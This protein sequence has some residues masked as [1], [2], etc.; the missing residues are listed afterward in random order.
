MRLRRPILG[1]VIAGTGS[2]LVLFAL[3][4]ASTGQTLGPVNPSGKLCSFET[5][6]AFVRRSTPSLQ[7]SA[8]FIENPIAVPDRGQIKE[9]DVYLHILGR[10]ASSHLSSI[11][12]RQCSFGFSVD[13]S[14]GLEFELINIGTEGHSACSFN[15]CVSLLS[16]LIESAAIDEKEFSAAASSIT[17]AMREADVVHL[18]I[19]DLAWSAQRRKSCV[20]FMDRTPK[21]V[22][23]LIFHRATLQARTSKSF[24]DGLAISKTY[25]APG[26]DRKSRRNRLLPNPK[27][28]SVDSLAM[29]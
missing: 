17:A 15:Q 12:L 23:C 4:V 14:S 24:R 22:F 27:A 2:L 21:S 19:G 5:N 6:K 3:T 11:T 9:H 16:D 29:S 20:R 10:F 8:T 7:I 25:C 18:D 13:A 1:S 28:V 26:P